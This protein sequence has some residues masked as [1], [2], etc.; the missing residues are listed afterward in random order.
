M[1][2]ITPWFAILLVVGGFSVA[3]ADSNDIQQTMIIIAI[4]ASGSSGTGVQMTK[5]IFPNEKSCKA[6]ARILEQDIQG[7]FVYARCLPQH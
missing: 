3:S 2:W 6:A 4:S 1:K 5:T 7:G